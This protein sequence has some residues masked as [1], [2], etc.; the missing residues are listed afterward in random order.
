MY[1]SLLIAAKKQKRLIIIFL[2]TVFLPAVSLAVFGIIALSNERYRLEKQLEEEQQQMAGYIQTQISQNIETTENQLRQLSL[3]EPVIHNNKIETAS[4]LDTCLE[5]N[6]LLDQ[7][8]IVYQNDTPWFHQ[9]RMEHE[10]LHSAQTSKKINAL[11]TQ[12]T[13]AE[14]YEFVQ[15]NHQEAIEVYESAFQNTNDKNLQARILNSIGRNYLKLKN[16]D[17]AAGIYSKIIND[18]PQTRT[19]A[20]IPLGITAQ[21]QLIDCYRNSETTKKALKQVLNAFQTLVQNHAELTENQLKTYAEIVSESY[22]DL[23]KELNSADKEHFANRFQNLNTEYKKVL[24]RWQMVN[25]LKNKCLPEIELSLLNSESHSPEILRY[26]EKVNNQQFLILA[27]AIPDSFQ[28]KTS[29]VIGVKINNNYLFNRLTEDNGNENFSVSIQNV[30]GRQLYG[31]PDFTANA[32]VTTAF[33]EGNFPPWRI[34]VAGNQHDERLFRGIFRSFYFWTILTTILILIFGVFLII[35][36]LA[37]EMEV[38]KVKSEFVSS[39][40]HEF[41]TPIT[42][43]K[44]LTERLLDGKIKSPERLKEYYSVIYEDTE[45][46]SRLVS[47]FLDFAKM[48]EGKKQYDFVK[49]GL[50]Q[51]VPQ[52]IKKLKKDYHEERLK[53]NLEI[54]EELPPLS[55]DRNSMELALRNLID[56]AIKFSENAVVDVTVKQNKRNVIIQVTDYG[57]GITK[58]EQDKIFEKFYQGT[59]ANNYSATGSGL[60]LTIVKRI[61]EAHGGEI[62][63]KSETGKGSTFTVV[64]PA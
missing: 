22:Q 56:N 26:T 13:R 11:E 53:I 25:A 52:T 58:K 54:N 15:K 60:G 47:N 37:H 31:R 34:Q 12:F 63:V 32:P 21:L 42:S 10:N 46:L 16:F 5:K 48:E 1:R 29:G 55:I 50:Q 14:E 18:Y 44:A 28:T 43:I 17:T 45:N 2:I 3:S 7:F 19:R 62:R 20:G 33:F 51:W 30:E 35:R 40:S 8:F 38:L 36:T 27:T 39:V 24:S 49:T 23:V 64:L 41:K 6:P 57:K 9:F 59:N 61:A 4:L